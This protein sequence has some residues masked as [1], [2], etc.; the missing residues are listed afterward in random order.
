MSAGQFDG[1]ISE[2][3]ELMA[4][5]EN[6]ADEILSDK[7]Q[8]VE[9]DRKRNQNREALRAISKK[10]AVETTSDKVWFCLGKTF[11]KFPTETAEII[12]NDNRALLDDE[13]NKIRDDL[14]TKVAHLYKLEG[15]DRLNSGFFLKSLDAA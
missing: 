13:I 9:L 15:D 3:I 10:D 7:F 12:L 2:T 6:A 8:I 5:I 14:K 4:K 11:V 1:K